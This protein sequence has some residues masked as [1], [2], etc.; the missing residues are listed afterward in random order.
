MRRAAVLG[1]QP[2]Q[3]VIN[4][5]NLFGDQL[6]LVGRQ[7]LGDDPTLA[8]EHEATNGGHRLDANAIALSFLGEQLVVDDL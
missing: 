7:V 1:R 4:V 6:E 3:R 8:V 2:V 5:A